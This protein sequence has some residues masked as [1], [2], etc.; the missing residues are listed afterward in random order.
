MLH[1]LLIECLLQIDIFVYKRK[2]SKITDT[3]CEFQ[4]I[5]AKRGQTLNSIQLQHQQKTATSVIITLFPF[6]Q[7]ETDKEKICK[8]EKERKRHNRQFYS[9]IDLKLQ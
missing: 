7:I 4:V 6:F 3:I 5:I 9:K 1:L 2:V 8:K